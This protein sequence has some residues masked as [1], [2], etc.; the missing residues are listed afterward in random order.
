[1]TTSSLVHVFDPNDFGKTYNTN[2]N[3]LVVLRLALDAD[4]VSL[5]SNRLL[6]YSNDMLI[7]VAV[8]EIY[9]DK[10]RHVALLQYN[11]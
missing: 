7:R 8:C 1:M 2:M 9:M 3:P 5:L 4:Q 11:T 10:K 6:I